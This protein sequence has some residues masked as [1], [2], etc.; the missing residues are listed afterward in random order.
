MLLSR[1]K[2]VK[3]LIAAACC[4]FT[5][6]VL[7]SVTNAF[8]TGTDTSCATSKAQSPSGAFSEARWSS[9][10]ASNYSAG[11]KWCAYNNAAGVRVIWQSDG[12]LVG[13]TGAH[14][15]GTATWSTRTSGKPGGATTGARLAFQTDGNV[16]IY[17]SAG[18]ALWATQT[19]G[20]S[21]GNFYFSVEGGPNLTNNGGGAVASVHFNSEPFSRWYANIQSP[22]INDGSNGAVPMYKTGPWNLD[23]SEDFNTPAST[24][25]FASRYIDS[26]C[27]YADG[28]G[29]RYYNSSVISAH[30]GVMDFTLDG[31]KGGAGS[32]GP[33]GNC[34]T[35][36][37]GRYAFRFRATGASNYTIAHMLW[38]SDD[39]WGEGEE[40][41]PEGH[42]NT[43]MN[44]YQHGTGCGD[45]CP[46]N[47][48]QKASGVNF[49]QWHTATIEWLP[50]S[51]S[52]YMDS[53]LIY[54]TTQDVPNTP[55]RETLQLVA[56]NSA[57]A[58][59]FYVAWVAHWANQALGKTTPVQAG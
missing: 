4:F 7:T 33:P 16:V 9:T 10:K 23:F 15:G 30:N 26:W 27:G 43:N 28:T 2:P 1:P 38:P 13:Y 14:S 32:F 18:K 48:A 59:H 24:S 12:N 55:H 47:V 50:G 3:L 34:W 56:G 42:L 51:I 58:G 41:W 35:S 29:G 21:T 53:T 46:Q 44:F 57:T 25:T 19:Y 45:F 6:T 31:T 37:Y 40:D 8:A 49:S 39:V 11:Q 17:N 5:A 22:M 36:S 54:S 52:F 20:G